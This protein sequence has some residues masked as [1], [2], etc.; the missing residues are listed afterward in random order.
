MQ[1][2]SRKGLCLT[3]GSSDLLIFEKYSLQ[4]SKK[5][6]FLIFARIV[7]MMAKGKHLEEKGLKKIRL[8]VRKMNKR[9]YR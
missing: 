7:K 8:M 3:V 6:D 9:K 5:K 2:I 4:T 1:T